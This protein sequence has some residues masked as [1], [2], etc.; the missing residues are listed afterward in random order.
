MEACV[1]KVACIEGDNECVHKGAFWR[2]RA[3]YDERR[4]AAQTKSERSD[5]YDLSS[6][7]STKLVFTQSAG[8]NRLG[9]VLRGF[10]N[11]CSDSLHSL[12]EA[13]FPSNRRNTST[14]EHIEGYHYNT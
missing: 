13:G 14:N 4:V 11:I 12:R 7:N 8:L 2:V 1:Y 5:P 6:S 10:Y 3:A 9:H